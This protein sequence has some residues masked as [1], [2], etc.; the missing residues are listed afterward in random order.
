MCECYDIH[1]LNKAEQFFIHYYKTTD[2]KFG[3]NL[4]SGGGGIFNYK[5]S[6]ETKQKISKANKGEK[7]YFYGKHHSEETKQKIAESNKRRVGTLSIINNICNLYKQGVTRSKILDIINNQELSFQII[8]RILKE[9]KIY[10]RHSKFYLSNEEK[11]FILNNYKGNKAK[12]MREF[13][14]NFNKNITIKIV[15]R[16]LLTK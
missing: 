10:Q 13:N 6:E 9:N 8:N 16:I 4:T 7:N 14:L 2:K 12:L 1:D 15:R 5:H 11:D 3:Y